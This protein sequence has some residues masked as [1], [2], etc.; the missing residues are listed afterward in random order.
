[1]VRFIDEHRAAFGVGPTCRKPPIAPSQHFDA[2][3]REQEPDS[4]PARVERDAPLVTEIQR[5]HAQSDVMPST[6][7]SLFPA[8]LHVSERGDDN[9]MNELGLS[10]GTSPIP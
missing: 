9:T 4:V 6:T 3:R 5:V 2:R 7:P 1:M 8:S 10:Y